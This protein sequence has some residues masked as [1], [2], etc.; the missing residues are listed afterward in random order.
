MRRDR[1][2]DGL[3]LRAVL[4]TG[5]Y[6]LPSC[7]ARLPRREN[8]RF[9]GDCAAAERAGYRPCKRCSPNG[10]SANARH[11]AAIEAARQLIESSDSAPSLDALA[12]H[13]GM[14]RFHFHRIFKA[15]VGMTPRAYANSRLQIR[16]SRRRK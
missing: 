3:F 11:A 12:R 6:C 7:G 15:T 4:T 13:A 14:S 8:V 10:P 16:R 5:I 2:A 9:F 1:S